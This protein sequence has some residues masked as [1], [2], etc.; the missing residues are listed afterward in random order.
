M[1][2]DGGCQGELSMLPLTQASAGLR[3]RMDYAP[4]NIT[5]YPPEA[6]TY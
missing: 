4:V 3:E 1:Y 5:R 6:R 2:G